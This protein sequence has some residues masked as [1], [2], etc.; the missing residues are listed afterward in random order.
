[1]IGHPSHNWIVSYGNEFPQGN[2]QEAADLFAKAIE[3]GQ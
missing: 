1:M 2:Q 3:N